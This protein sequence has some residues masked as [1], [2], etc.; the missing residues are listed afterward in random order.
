[1]TK[2][3]KFV[4]CIDRL[5][6]KGWNPAIIFVHAYHESGNFKKVIGKNNYWGIKSS[7]RWKG[8]KVKKTTHEFISVEKAEKL[9][10]KP[11]KNIELVGE[12]FKHGKEWHQKI[13]VKHWFRD[14]ETTEEA[15]NWYIVLIKRLYPMSYAYRSDYKV[16]FSWLVK[17][18][19]KYATDKKYAGKLKRLYESLIGG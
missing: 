18:I 4:K 16:F 6:V 13:K 5:W 1:M 14:W 7:S 2:K 10:K 12:I 8:L 19:Y 17:G 9:R 3:E 11:N 15:L